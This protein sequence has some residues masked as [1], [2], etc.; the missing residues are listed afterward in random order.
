[1][2]PTI[3]DFEQRFLVDKGIVVIEVDIFKVPEGY[4]SFAAINSPAYDEFEGYGASIDKDKS[5]RLALDDLRKQIKEEKNKNNLKD[6]PFNEAP[7][8]L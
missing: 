3:L 5:I 4:R 7:N 8:L 1:M 6:G 2:N